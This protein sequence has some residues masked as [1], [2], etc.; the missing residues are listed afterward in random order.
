MIAS[1]P[2]ACRYDYFLKGGSKTTRCFV[3]EMVEGDIPELSSDEAPIAL[4]WKDIKR[5]EPFEKN[6]RVFDGRF[7][8][9]LGGNSPQSFPA[10]SLPGIHQV[11]LEPVDLA[12]LMGQ[13]GLQGNVKAIDAV[14][15]GRPQPGPPD[16]ARIEHDLGNNRSE[17]FARAERVLGSLVIV[18]GNVWRAVPEPTLRNRISELD[19]NAQVSLSLP[20]FGD[21]STPWG[22]DGPLKMSIHR[23]TQHDEWVAFHKAAGKRSRRQ[24]QDHCLEVLLPDAFTFEPVR[25]RMGRA[26]GQALELLGPGLWKWGEALAGEY[27]G[28]RQAYEGY[29]ADMPYP[30]ETLLARAKALTLASPDKDI[31]YVE[32]MAD[33][34]AVEGEELP[35]SIGEMVGW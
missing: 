20:H 16:A 15:F 19:V 5:G 22:V 14:I 28:L 12:E 25:N 10:S 11:S 35:V 21:V 8:S 29:L 17:V 13:D 4:R 26:V 6:V 2:F 24:P 3:G 7:L 18:D 33:I 30:V 1:I 27:L 9:P 32:I 34:L 23:V 31:R